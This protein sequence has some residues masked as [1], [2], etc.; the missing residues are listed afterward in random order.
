MTHL[1][2]ELNNLRESLNQM[3]YQVM[4]QLSKSVDS[5]INFD[6]DL[7]QEVIRHEKRIN[8]LEIQIDKE[9][10]TIFTLMTP[11]AK[12]MR[13][14]FA[15]LKI[16]NDLERIADYAENISLMVMEL[17]KPFDKQLLVELKLE[18]M[19]KTA[20]SMLTDT[21]ASYGN[22][23]AEMAR[24]VFTADFIINEIHR[25]AKVIIVNQCKKDPDNITS[26]IDLWS[27]VRRIERV[28][29]HITN[30]AEEII[31]YLEATVLKHS[32]KDAPRK[33][34]KHNKA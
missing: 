1:Q 6:K 19:S 25:K 34:G 22:E 4:N 26:Y 8:A 7:A 12:D 16:N 27:V 17:E 5:L 29:D 3:S 15:T 30:V 33:N 11:V 20:L 28:G 32:G 21:I 2:D 10:E 23:N 18:E 14:V 31:F 9:C 24:S 13:F